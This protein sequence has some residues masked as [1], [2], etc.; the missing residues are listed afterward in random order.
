MNPQFAEQYGDF[1]R[2][3]WWFR[4]R[5]EILETAIRRELGAER[6]IAIASIGC[7]PA[8]G[9]WWL[10]E[11]M[12]DGARVIGLD[13]DPLH[14]QAGSPAGT[15]YVIGRVEAQPFATASLDAVLALDVIEHVDDDAAGLREIAR[16]LKP[17]GLLVLTVP[18]LPSLWGT[19]DVVNHH[20]RRYTRRT[21]LDAFARAEL[22]R[23]RT[24]YFNTLLL[25]PIAAVRWVRRALGHTEGEQS[26]FE[27]NRPGLANEALRAVFAAERHLVG[28]IPMPIGVS[29][30]ATLRLS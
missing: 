14:A 26:D 12:G 7:G 21:L 23:P 24:T 1:E 8:D 29:L 4:A 25:P 3:H 11:L 13:A 22:P 15:Q 28:R 9:L 6:D 10:R 20:R 30:L 27:D 5:R 18:A 17:D 2:W 16:T 19:Q